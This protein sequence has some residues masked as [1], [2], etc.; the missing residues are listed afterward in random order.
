MRAPIGDAATR[1]QPG[2]EPLPNEADEG[3][4]PDF[5]SACKPAIFEDIPLTHCVADPA[6]HSIATALAPNSG[7]QAGSIEGWRQGRDAANIAFVVN[8]GM[9]GDDLRPVG[10]FVRDADRFVEIDRGS[11]GGN[12]YLKP[13]GV[14]FGSE[15]NWRILESETFVR[16]VGTRP[17]FGTQ[18]GPMLVINGEMHPE[19][20]ENGPSKAIRN[21]V[22]IDR[23]GR[24][25]FVISGEPLS[26][27]QLARF[28][29]D[30]LDVPD[31]L[32][33]DG[34]VS[35]L[36]DPVTGRMDEGRV[37]PLLVVRRK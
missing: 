3:P 31:A 20:S 29:R 22:G 18:S 15:G 13:N 8:A 7:Q 33:L 25:H 5:A 6:V 4:A 34:N 24:A 28:Y 19:F 10:Y 12:F 14:F 27:G 9:Y 35:A 23:Q 30:E 17:Q 32:Y 26:F 1:E 11:A 16:T 2:V 36:W 21:G 37:G